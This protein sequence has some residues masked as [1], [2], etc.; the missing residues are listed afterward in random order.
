MKD[1]TIIFP[2]QL[3]LKHPA[4]ACGRPIYLIEEFLFYHIQAFHKQRLVL[5][6]TAM[7]KYATMLRNHHHD[8]TILSA[9]DLTYR[10][11]AFEAL[12]K[13]RIETIHVAEFA[14]EWLD[15]D[16]HQAA[17]RYGWNVI[18]HPSPG[19]MCSHQELQSFFF[20][21]E[22]Y[23]MA[24]FYA[25][26]RRSRNILMEGDKP[27]GGKYSFDTEN[28]KKIPKNLSIPSFWVPPRNQE[29]EVVIEEIEHEFPHA[30]G[31]ASPFVYPTTHQEAHQ[32]LCVFLQ[33]KIASFGNYQDAMRKEDSFLFHSVLSPMLNIG[34]I[35]P[36]EVLDAAL[37]YAERH[38]I[39]MN[40]LEG[41]A[42]QILGWREFVQ[43]SYLLKGSSQRSR[44]FFDHHD[45]IPQRFWQGAV[46]IE[47]IDTT[48]QRA[49]QT[50][51][52]NHIERLM[53]LGNFLLLTETSPHEIYTWFMGHFVDAYDW[54]MV[55][56]V[57][58][59]SQYADG[60]T[61]VTKPYI[62]SSNYIVK[63]SNYPKG[64]WTEVW[65]GLFWRFLNKHHSLFSSNHRTAQLIKFA[66]K[67]KIKIENKI[68]KSECWLADYKSG[69]AKK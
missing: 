37:A 12:G 61:I 11:S 2:D 62:S 31:K 25:Y 42:R 24:Q 33:D 51:Y 3:F 63:M 20:E 1:V 47:P 13:K 69:Y 26:Q 6:R 50:G 68:R 52:C 44:N 49:L 41:F 28:R 59:M 43:A 56:N 55:P 27:I 18:M 29:V 36:K 7:R 65:D 54:V 53:L 35:T 58:G 34:L 64:D 48:V 16:L 15:Q 5:L 39:P 32:A 8:V 14:D 66:V 40:S 9:K 10:G 22:H 21:K 4:I 45:P 30:I 38:A 23:A 60:G 67:N 19:F 46:G 57:Y 17:K